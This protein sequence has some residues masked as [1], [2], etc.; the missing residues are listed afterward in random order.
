[1][2]AG[3]LSVSARIAKTS[4][5]LESGYLS[6]KVVTFFVVEVRQLGIQWEVRRRYSEFHRFHELLSLQWSD[7][8]TLQP[9]LL[10]SQECDDVAQ[11]M[12]EVSKEHSR[13][14]PHALAAPT[15]AHLAPSRNR[16][17]PTAEAPPLS[18]AALFLCQEP[19]PR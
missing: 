14:Q 5:E 9:K 8:P 11:R 1:M 13:C 2:G 10:F 6:E 19:P 18:T 12:V 16:P 15:C 4:N 17:P 7:L 3:A